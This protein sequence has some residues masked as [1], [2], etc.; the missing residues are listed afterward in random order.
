MINGCYA[1][2][3]AR[4]FKIDHSVV[5]KLMR[6]KKVPVIATVPYGKGKMTVFDRND[7]TKVLREHMAERERV[8][9]AAK[10][11]APPAVHMVDIS[12]LEKRINVLSQAVE[13]LLEIQQVLREQNDLLQKQNREIF[14]L[15]V[16]QKEFLVKLADSFGFKIEEPA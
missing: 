11:A 4:E 13:D 6:D 12:A 14:K 1:N 7:A 10:A 9:E 3:L 2:E 16:G 8:K 15:H 5:T